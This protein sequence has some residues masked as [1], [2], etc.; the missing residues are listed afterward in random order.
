MPDARPPSPPIHPDPLTP[1]PLPPPIQRPRLTYRMLLTGE[2]L[3]PSDQQLLFRCHRDVATRF[4]A[5]GAVAGGLMGWLVYG[6]GL[7]TPKSRFV[8]TMTATLW[9]GGVATIGA[10]HPCLHSWAETDDPESVL[11]SE[12]TEQMLLHNPNRALN[13]LQAEREKQMTQQRTAPATQ[14]QTQQQSRQ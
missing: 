2:G 9:G 1:I 13:M 11:R 3:S 12:I 10:T 7:T 5:G 4:V 14:T 6:R 8:L